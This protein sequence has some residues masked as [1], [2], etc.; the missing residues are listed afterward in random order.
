MRKQMGKFKKSCV[1]VLFAL[2]AVIMTVGI[3]GTLAWIVA[4]G[5]VTNTFVAG[6]VQCSIDETFDHVS[7]SSIKVIN[8]GNV[9]EY[10]RVA[11]IGNWCDTAGNVVA[12]WNGAIAPAIGWSYQDGYYYYN[13]VIAPG[14]SSVNLLTSPIT[15][16]T[17]PEGVPSGAEL[18]I[19]VLAQAIQSKPAETVTETWG[20][21]P[22]K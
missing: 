1:I 20:Y 18:K 4:T 8:T 17:L 16:A 11:V 12:P 19:D 13:T 9:D 10:V 7:K 22:S 14:D 15:S 6:D 21:S 3:G 5:T 2:V